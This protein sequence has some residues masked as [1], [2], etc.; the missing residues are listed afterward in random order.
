MS[1]KTLFLAWQAQNPSREWFPIG[2]LDA[3]VA[4][5]LYRFR[6]T[7]GAE[8]AQAEGDF[9]LIT[10]FPNLNRDYRAD[11]LWS[12]FTNRVLTPRRPDFEVY[13]ENL[14]LPQGTVDP[15]EILSVNGGSRVTDSYEVFPK[16]DKQPDGRFAC[17]FF[18]HGWRHVSG[19]AEAR[20]E[21]LQPGDDLTIA[22]ELTNPVT[23]VAVQVQTSDYLVL[24]WAPRYL[25]PDLTLAVAEA[26]SE[27]SATVVRVNPQPAPS[28]QRVLIEMTGR[29]RDH[30]PMTAPDFEPLAVDE[31]KLG[32]PKLVAAAD[33]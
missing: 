12:L 21:S 28:R 4:Q 5:S 27:Y 22:L 29:W 31:P 25:V 33:Q 2:R 10:E 15:I 11:R 9:R 23:R 14:G 30:E 32:E 18:L 20:L 17:R 6:Y 3:D 7:A 1:E 19:A 16:I 26:P 13:L 24:G 8:R